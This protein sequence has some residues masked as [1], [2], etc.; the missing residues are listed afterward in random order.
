M[1]ELVL[2]D[3]R[4]RQNISQ[5]MIVYNVREALARTHGDFGTA[6]CV[7]SLSVKYLNA[8][9]GIILLRCSKAFYQLLWS[10]LPFITSLENR[11]QRFPCFFNT[12]H[13]GG[14]IRTC[15]K[16]LIR[17]NKQQLHRLL[18]NCTNAE[19]RKAIEQS[20]AS[21]TLHSVEE[22][23]FVMGNEDDGM[24][25]LLQDLWTLHKD[26]VFLWIKLWINSCMIWLERSSF[27]SEQ[28]TLLQNQTPGLTFVS[29]QRGVET[30]SPLVWIIGWKMNWT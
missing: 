24:E 2:E 22:S 21:C 16:F 6:A 25:W 12:L 1:C 7:A 11:G 3:P 15:Q 19:E 14:T 27:D 8:Y 26:S 9:T 5:G 17:Y 28:P 10:S 23:E 30:T 18:N 4:L 20:I 13:V 29:M